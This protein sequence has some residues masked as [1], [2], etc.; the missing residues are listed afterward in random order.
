M[1]EAK[2]SAHLVVDEDGNIEA[3]E[4][5]TEVEPEVEHMEVEVKE[6]KKK[7]KHTKVEKKEEKETSPMDDK[8]EE[9]EENIGSPK[10]KRIVKRFTN[11]EDVEMLKFVY[12]KMCDPETGTVRKDAKFSSTAPKLWAEYARRLEQP[13]T[14]TA[15]SMQ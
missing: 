8:Q 6:Q 12:E 9:K 3:F 13:R 2:R 7:R 1:E 4:M 5:K 11:Q 15:Y 10:T 14:T